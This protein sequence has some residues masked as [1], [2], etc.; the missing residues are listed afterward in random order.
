MR[1]LNTRVV[2]ALAL[3]GAALLTLATAGAANAQG[4]R[5]LVDGPHIGRC[6]MGGCSWFDVTGFTMVREVPGAALLRLTTREGGSENGRRPYPTSSRGVRIRWSQ[7][8]EDYYIFCST[9]RPAVIMRGDGSAW[10][11]V[12]IQPATPAG[13]TEFITSVYNHVCHHGVRMTE[14]RAQR[15]GYRDGE[16]GEVT[17]QRPEDIF[18]QAG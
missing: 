2:V 17:L 1:I 15:L 5:G 7:P 4:R 3:G 10:S 18:D 6:H 14:A 11:A 13:A 16:L 12:P 8:A 9:R